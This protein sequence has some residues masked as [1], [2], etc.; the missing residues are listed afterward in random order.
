MPAPIDWT[1]LAKARGLVLPAEEIARVLEPLRTLESVFR[2]LTRR[3][4]SDV[5]PAIVFRADE[6]RT[7]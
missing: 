6:G 1:A 3:I 5:Q 4:P 2:P 7:E